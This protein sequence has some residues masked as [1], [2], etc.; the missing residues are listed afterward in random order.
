MSQFGLLFTVETLIAYS[1]IS[2]EYKYLRVGSLDVEFYAL[3]IGI[4]HVTTMSQ[5]GLF[6]IVKTLIA[7]PKL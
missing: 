6:L 2:I 1:A 4:L 3:S 5:L 7:L